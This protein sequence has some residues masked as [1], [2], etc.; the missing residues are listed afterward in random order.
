MLSSR[1]TSRG[2]ET[3]TKLAHAGQGRTPFV[4][5]S[6]QGRVCE[7]RKGMRDKCNKL[8]E[9]L[10]KAIDSDDRL[11]EKIKA[12]KMQIVDREAGKE[13]AFIDKILIYYRCVGP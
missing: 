2:Q 1:E 9:K 5:E 7:A 12:F 13:V 11:E 4:A 6:D 10:F 8:P 3:C